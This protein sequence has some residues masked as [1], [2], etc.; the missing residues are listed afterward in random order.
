MRSVVI[1]IVGLC[2]DLIGPHTPYTNKQIESYSLG[3]IEPNIPAVTCTAQA[4]YLTGQNPS[5]HGIVANGWYDRTLHEHHFWK[6]SNRLVRGEKLW[7]AIRNQKKNFTCA[8][9][10]WWYNMYSSADY[11]ITPRP[12]YL[13]DGKK[14]FD[15][16]S[17]PLS[18]RDTIK[19]DLGEFPFPSFWGPMAGLP[20]SKWIAESA[21]WVEEKYSPDLSLVYLP[22]LDYNLQRLGPKDPKIQ[23]DV[24]AIDKIV[25][26]LVQFYKEREIQPFLLSEYGISETN[27]CIHINRLFRSKNWLTIKDELGL[28]LLDCGASKVFAITDHQIAHI[29][30]NDPTLKKEVIEALSRIE[31]VSEILYDDSLKKAGLN[32]FRSGDLVAIAKENS[33][34]SYYYWENDKK[35]PDFARCID[36]HRKFGY[37]PCEL[38]I[39]SEITLPKLKI[40]STLIKKKLG[41]RTLMDVIPLNTDLVKGS[42]GCKPKDKNFWPVLIGPNNLE[43]ERKATSIFDY[44]IQNL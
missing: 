8:Q 11:S 24:R 9:L 35:A 17:Q 37:D 38:F 30:L 27:H 7:E 16:Y 36:I 10:F 20:S 32:H 22:H 13:S 2:K 23:E 28:E 43:S 14:V 18:I 34:F 44:L 25:G 39:D 12:L 21:K 42:H 15:I 3:L 26:D 4:T 19:N 40:L 1:N 41:F 6:Q 31:G 33:W 5:E 29:Y